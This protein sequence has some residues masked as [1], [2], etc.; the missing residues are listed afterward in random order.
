LKSKIID[1][2]EHMK[3]ADDRR[4]ESLFA[5]AP[6][7]DDGFSERVMHRIRSKLR[8]RRACFATALALGGAIALKPALWLV[9]FVLQL[10]REIPGGMPV[11]SADA[12]PSAAMLAAGGLLFVLTVVGLRLF[13]D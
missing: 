5:T 10:L 3:D 8:L 12:L 7:P 9:T 1:M 4:L 6:V 13:E 11:V 2:A